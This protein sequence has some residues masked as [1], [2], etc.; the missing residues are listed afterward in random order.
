M[1]IL[2]VCRLVAK[3]EMQPFGKT[4]YYGY[5]GVSADGPHEIGY[6]RDE[7]KVTTVVRDGDTVEVFEV[8]VHS[9]PL[10]TEP[11]TTYQLKLETM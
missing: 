10:N 2:E 4:D 7:S 6:A 3:V 9:D 5:A 1:N 11:P 8:S